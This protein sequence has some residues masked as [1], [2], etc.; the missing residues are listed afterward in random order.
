MSAAPAPAIALTGGNAPQILVVGDHASNHVPDD[1]ELGI[2]AALMDQHMAIDIGV[3]GVARKLHAKFG[4]DA[5][6]ASHSRLVADLN[7]HADDPAAIPVSSDGHDIPGNRLDEAG[8]A[9]RL[10]RYHHPYHDALT[11]RLIAQ[12][13]VLILSLHS[14]TPSLSSRPEEMRPW[15]IGILY[16]RYEA[17][18]KRAIELLEQSGLVVG[19]QLPYSGKLLN[20]TMDRHAEASGIPYLGLEMRQ[21]IVGDDAG[22]QRMAS[23]IGPVCMKIAESLASGA[24]AGL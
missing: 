17:A 16:N 4:F 5:F 8:R 14:F 7:R 13:P 19:D 15:H 23:L 9:L 1:V 18:S 21:D 12:R 22:E 10:A 11:G 2:D 3:M 6:L 20:A 24:I